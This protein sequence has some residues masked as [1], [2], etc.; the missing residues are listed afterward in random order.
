MGVEEIGHKGQ[1]QTGI[2]GDQRLGINVTTAVQGI[3]ILQDHFG[4]GE[5]LW[6][7]QWLQ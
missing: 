6:F 5:G 1:V 4:A 2:P 7:I 3:G